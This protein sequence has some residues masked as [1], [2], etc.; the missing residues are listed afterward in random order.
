[1]TRFVFCLCKPWKTGNEYYTIACG[2]SS[3]IFHVEMVEGKGRPNELGP[4]KY[5]DHG[6][7]KIDLLLRMTKSNW[8]TGALCT[9]IA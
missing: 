6:G 9:F 2:L 3:I 8:N 4:P 7:K 1:M 5:E